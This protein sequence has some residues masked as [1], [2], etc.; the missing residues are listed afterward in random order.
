MIKHSLK[1]T[2]KLRSENNVVFLCCLK[3]NFIFKI[4]RIEVYIHFL[5]YY[6]LPFSRIIY[7]WYIFLKI[8]RYFLSILLVL[9]DRLPYTVKYT[10]SHL[11]R[12]LDLFDFKKTSKPMTTHLGIKKYIFP[13]YYQKFIKKK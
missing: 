4:L 3:I 8:Y 7:S 10:I 1:V 9:L 6:Y 2:L 13:D 11:F 12:H 5:S